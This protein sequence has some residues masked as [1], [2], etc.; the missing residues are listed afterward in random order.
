MIFVSV[1]YLYRDLDQVEML[2]P[3]TRFSHIYESLTLKIDL[4]VKFRVWP[5]HF[6]HKWIFLI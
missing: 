6:K 2:R 5:Q 4:R 3:Y 1:L